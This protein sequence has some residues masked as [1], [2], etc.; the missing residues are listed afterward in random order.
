MGRL[1]E[2]RPRK[3]LDDSADRELMLRIGEGDPKALERVL[4]IYWPA[5]VAYARTIVGHRDGAEDVAQETFIRPWEKRRGWRPAGS[6]KPL[7]LR[8]AR[9]LAVSEQRRLRGPATPG[10]A[11]W[12]TTTRQGNLPLSPREGTRSSSGCEP[13]HA[14]LRISHLADD[15]PS[16]SP[17][18]TTSPTGRSPK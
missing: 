14:A 9:N 1:T 8:I 11:G 17:A 12:R 3:P 5:V 2:S 13:S 7:L 10:R 16:C 6:L 4:T 18:F 15:G